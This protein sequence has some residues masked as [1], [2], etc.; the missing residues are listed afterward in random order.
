[1]NG[2]TEQVDREGSEQQ[3]FDK[4]RFLE[5]IVSIDDNQDY[6]LAEAKMLISSEMQEFNKQSDDVKRGLILREEEDEGLILLNALAKNDCGEE[7]ASCVKLFEGEARD[8]LY[9][10]LNIDE[11]NPLHIAMKQ[12]SSSVVKAI[13]ENDKDNNL[14]LILPDGNDLSPLANGL[15][16]GAYEATSEF[17]KQLQEKDRQEDIKLKDNKERRV[18]P[19]LTQ[20]AITNCDSAGNTAL[21]MIAIETEGQN[22][23]LMID[24]VLEHAQGE[25]IYRDKN[26]DKETARELFET[27]NEMGLSQKLKDKHVE[28]LFNNL[29]REAANGSDFTNLSRKK[30]KL[31]HYLE[32]DWNKLDEMLGVDSPLDGQHKFSPGQALR[33]N[34]EEKRQAY[35]GSAERDVSTDIDGML[36]FLTVGGQRPEVPSRTRS[37]AATA[38]DGSTL[39]SASTNGKR[40]HTDMSNAFDSLDLLSGYDN[41]PGITD[42]LRAGNSAMPPAPRLPQGGFAQMHQNGNEEGKDSEE[43]RRPAAYDAL[44]GNQNG[45]RRR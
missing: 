1:M 25:L 43:Q 13:L 12:N 3:S 45:A 41:L 14:D 17:L 10:T 9:D 18:E 16:Y 2:K 21:H 37:A 8:A 22:Q 24:L 44:N 39:S 23:E 26:N 28:K 31:E 29:S 7:F 40:S 42:L 32:G 19:R 27:N 38:P 20:A 15:K 6:S 4:N 30:R 34:I 36:S 5:A 33:R 11:R 35:Q